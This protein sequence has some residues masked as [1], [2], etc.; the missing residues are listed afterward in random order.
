MTA[1]VATVD[2]CNLLQTAKDGESLS[3]TAQERVTEE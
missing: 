1:Q 3:R 2:Q